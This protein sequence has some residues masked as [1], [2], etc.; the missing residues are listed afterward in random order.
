M[1]LK[2]HLQL[3]CWGGAG[4]GFSEMFTCVLYTKF[5]Q[6]LQEGAKIIVRP[7]NEAGWVGL[8][9]L[10]RVHEWWVGQSGGFERKLFLNGPFIKFYSSDHR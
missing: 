2:N 5:I 7:Y 10:S 4:E 3:N 8:K 1:V 9:A 6:H